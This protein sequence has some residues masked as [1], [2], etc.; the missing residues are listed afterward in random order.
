VPDGFA[1]VEALP[2]TS[3]GKSMKTKLRQVFND[4]VSK[5]PA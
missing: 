3:T 4:W 2:R 5:K 1:F